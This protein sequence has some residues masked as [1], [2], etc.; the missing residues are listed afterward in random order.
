MEVFRNFSVDRILLADELVIQ[1]DWPQHRVAGFHPL[2][3]LFSEVELFDASKI[4]VPLQLINNFVNVKNPG[5][6]EAS[7]GPRAPSLLMTTWK[8]GGFLHRT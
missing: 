7:R 2:I 6:F 5:N 4:E 8:Y 3:L 1:Y